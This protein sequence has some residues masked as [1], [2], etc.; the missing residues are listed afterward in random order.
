MCTD[1][2]ATEAARLLTGYKLPA[3]L[4][5]DPDGQPYAIVRGSQLI[6]RLGSFRSDDEVP[7]GESVDA[8]HPPRHSC[9]PVK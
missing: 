2:D 4:V 9:P 1:D 8:S 6:G 3:L 5:V 7:V